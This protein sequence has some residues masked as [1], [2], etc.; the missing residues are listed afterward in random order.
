ER[1]PSDAQWRAAGRVALT[2]LP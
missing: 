1:R 2:R